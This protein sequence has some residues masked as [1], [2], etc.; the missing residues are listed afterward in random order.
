MSESRTGST[1]LQNGT[2]R[3]PS[4]NESEVANSASYSEQKGQ[5]RF[6][7]S[8][9][10]GSSNSRALGLSPSRDQASRT[11]WRLKQ[12]A[13]KLSRDELIAE[14]VNLSLTT[15]AVPPMLEALGGAEILRQAGSASKGNDDGEELGDDPDASPPPPS[16]AKRPSEVHPTTLLQITELMSS[17]VHADQVVERVVGALCS[18]LRAEQANYFTVLQDSEELLCFASSSPEMVGTSIPFSGIVGYVV[19]TGRAVNIAE[20]SAD[21]RHDRS[22][23][24]RGSVSPESVLLVP[25]RSSAGAVVAVVECVNHKSSATNEVVS[26]RSDHE[27]LLSAMGSLTSIILTKQALNENLF[28]KT[29]Q[30]EALHKIAELTSAEF[31]IERVID[32][33]L[34]ATAMVVNAKCIILY[35][36]DEP[37][38]RLVAHSLNPEFSGFSVRFDEGIAGNVALTG[39]AVN[40][41]EASENWR[42]GSDVF[43]TKFGTQTKSILV[44]P[45]T[46][47]LGTTVAVIEIRNKVATASMR[48][49]SYSMSQSTFSDSDHAL[50][51]SLA[52]TAASILR[53]AQLFDKTV[54]SQKRT[55]ALLQ[56]ADLMS[57]EIRTDQVVTRIIEA[58]YSLVNAER[59]SFFM[60][61][62]VIPGTGD[63]ALSVVGGASNGNRMSM[64]STTNSNNNNNGG[65]RF[66]N[67]FSQWNNGR[68]KP[69][70]SSDNEDGVS[71]DK[72]QS[73]VL[74]DPKIG[75]RDSVR[76]SSS[77]NLFDMAG[78][79]KEIVCHIS[80]D[81][82]FE[83][84]RIPWG[85]GIVGH[86][87]LTCKAVNIKDAYTDVRFNQEADR[88]TGFNTRS[89]L[90][91]PVTD[92]EG[93]SLAIIQAINK[94]DETC[95]DS[96]DEKNLLAL[97]SSAGMI[98]RKA[99]LYT[100][101]IIAEKKSRALLDL[102]KIT[103]KDSAPL[104]DLI[105]GI[106]D[107]AYEV[108][109][110]DRV[111]IFFVDHTNSEVFSIISKDVGKR[112][113]AFPIGTG[114]AGFV[115]ATGRV[116]NIADAYNSDKFDPSFD[117]K[118]GYRT[119]SVLC[120][121]V[122]DDGG[123]QLAVIQAL[124]KRR[125]V[126]GNVVE[127]KGG[128][129]EDQYISFT[130]DDEVIL[131]AFCN[132]IRSTVRALRA[133]ALLA[134][135][136]YLDSS[137]QSLIDLYSEKPS[138]IDGV[139][140]HAQ[141][142]FLWPDIASTGLEGFDELQSTDFNVW[143]YTPDSLMAFAVEIFREM[144]M[145][146]EFDIPGDT[147][148]LFVEG[149]RLK[150]RNNPFHNWYHGFSVMHF[151]YLI[152]KRTS[153]H[154]TLLKTDVLALLVASLCHDIDH[155]GNTNTYEI[156]SQSQLALVHN[157][158][159]VLENHHSHV[160]FTLLRDPKTDIF[161]NIPSAVKKSLRPSIIEAVLSTDMTVHFE[162]TK[163]LGK[164]EA[165][166][167]FD[168]SNPKER[169]ECIN[170]V[171][172]A[173]DLSGQVFPLPVARAWEERITQEFQNQALLEEAAKLPVASFMQGL[174][175]PIQRAKL[176][177]GFIDFV[178]TPWWEGVSRLYP[179][180]KDN[181]EMLLS[182]RNFY[183]SMAN[184]SSDGGDDAKKD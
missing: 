129:I 123:K 166:H 179:E 159:S 167:P 4:G 181:Y 76:R 32:K 10:S 71:V 126:M 146:S 149:V 119:K 72:R 117:R 34:R 139:Q 176:Q 36:V 153:A 27:A 6:D 90:T 172:H 169:Q 37:G 88:F 5:E 94:V 120:M 51:S 75:M 140:Y 133:E 65:N 150:Y 81:H 103:A 80:K 132:Q 143:K 89:I 50:V 87:A 156:N 106:V 74:N 55:D 68:N 67:D 44:V 158:I 130:T 52:A 105:S 157:D 95:F 63:D 178:L 7:N 127:A 145:V 47:Y 2:T 161:Q 82:G 22:A 17:D 113:L 137:T 60:V 98:L 43:D 101:A 25:V 164:R 59:I 56:I 100:S 175:D 174:N 162:S 184:P 99:Q 152:L 45:V 147:M 116:V 85:H 128:S 15:G 14:L 33:I 170:L 12:Q 115:A 13:S 121:P 48:R 122:T 31:G 180:L 142:Q 102:F 151:T 49:S 8:N 97:A 154:K 131:Q 38:K 124:N 134:Q 16:F 136:T 135:H 42:Y 111:T 28:S 144:G 78:P 61:E 96:D 173:A 171:I 39:R 70:A 79:A 21:W 53:Q 19:K 69:S 183:A 35:T 41:K 73:V 148:R 66:S 177:V 58:S 40:E 110:A 86:V 165:D 46:D 57:V 30:T 29:R 160:L 93:K 1:S 11:R 107:V 155:P 114:I 118:T 182:N 125:K 168:E 83:G 24:K 26:F 92:G 9:S 54:R 3:Q 20:L 109:D 62:D 77:K 138:M 91:V 104:Q 64:R 112:E 84:T 163:S 18:L 141:Q 108:L 23:D